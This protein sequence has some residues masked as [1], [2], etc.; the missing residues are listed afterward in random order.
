MDLFVFNIIHF[1]VNLWDSI[2]RLFAI[3]TFFC[4]IDEH[5]MTQN[6]EKAQ[7]LV[8][9]PFSLVNM[10]FWSRRLDKEK[11]KSKLALFSTTWIQFLIF[12]I[13]NLNLVPDSIWRTQLFD[14]YTVF[15]SVNYVKTNA[16]HWKELDG[17]PLKVHFKE[18]F[19]CCSHT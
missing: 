11:P 1:I 16:L 3:L 5:Q 8:H 15:I 10:Q 7:I 18:P 12:C 17:T 9:V 14:F 2:W 13:I 6:I 19:L 4:V